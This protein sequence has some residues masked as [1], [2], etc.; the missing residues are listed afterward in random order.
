[1]RVYLAWRQ[2]TYRAGP[3]RGR[4]R[5]AAVKACGVWIET[6]PSCQE[7]GHHG[8]GF[9]ALPYFPDQ[10]RKALSSTLGLRI[11]R[12]RRVIHLGKLESRFFR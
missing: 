2:G 11:L 9:P 1:M 5:V 4:A 6:F 12:V 3:P 10:A 7:R 8:P